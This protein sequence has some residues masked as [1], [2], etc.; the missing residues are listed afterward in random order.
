MLY[1]PKGKTPGGSEV[2]L[3]GMTQLTGKASSQTF[4]LKLL[5]V[6]I[7][8]R[9]TARTLLRVKTCMDIYTGKNSK[10]KLF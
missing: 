7:D 1:K 10:T 3:S 4:M 8:L 2:H 5:K 6:M 9:G